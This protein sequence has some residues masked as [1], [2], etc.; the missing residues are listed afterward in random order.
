VYLALIKSEKRA[1]TYKDYKSCLNPKEFIERVSKKAKS[2]RRKNTGRQGEQSK[3]ATKIL[4]P[5][6]LYADLRPLRGKLLKAITEDDIANVRSSIYKRGKRAQS[7]HVLRVLKAFF[8]WAADEP[9]SGLKKTN[10]ARDVKFL[11]KQKK[12]P[13]RVK[14]PKRP[15]CP[16][17]KEQIS[18]VTVTTPFAMLG[19]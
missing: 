19:K 4:T 6:P 7:N 1:A 18:P 5:A 9:E 2:Q 16:A 11:F 12:D 13:E 17:T 10:P 8:G 14:R 3:P 15:I